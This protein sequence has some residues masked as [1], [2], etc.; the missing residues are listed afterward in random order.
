MRPARTL[1]ACA[2]AWLLPTVALA[3]R[4]TEAFVDDTSSQNALRVTVAMD[5]ALTFGVGYV[6]TVPIDVDGFT[7]RLG[8]HADLS[9]VYGGTSW[10]VEGGVTMP[11]FE[12]PGVNVLASV[13][14]L[15]TSRC[16]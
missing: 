4:S 7:R 1:V 6:R 12:G 9:T 14:L 16:V 11:L 2:F 8:V 15:Y 5:P 13:C 10:D 3:Q